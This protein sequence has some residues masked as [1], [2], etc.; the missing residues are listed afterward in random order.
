M[1]AKASAAAFV[2]VFGLGIGAERA[3][4]DGNT[5][6]YGEYLRIVGSAPAGP[7]IARDVAL[8]GD[9]AYVTNEGAL[10]VFDI[11][12]PA[13]PM[14]I[15]FIPGPAQ[16]VAVL[17]PGQCIAV[18]DE[19]FGVRFYD[20]TNPASPT[21]LSDLP[22]AGGAD[23]MTAFRS[24]STTR[25][26]GT[27]G[28][29]YFTFEWPSCAVTLQ[30]AQSVTLPALANDVDG[31]GTRAYVAT[32]VGLVTIDPTMSPPSILGGPVGGAR[33]RVR[34]FPDGTHV[35]TTNGNGFQ[36]WDVTDP[37]NPTE[38]FA[39]NVTSIPLALD[40]FEEI[41]QPGQDIILAISD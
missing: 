6:D 21:F 40:V 37:S 41:H 2:A 16:Q 34:M 1:S 15:G 9:I 28:S 23:R 35:A 26:H 31:D 30:S 12:D 3:E 5:V 10:L 24:G 22:I 4:C 36:T 27:N 33:S 11:A 18:G 14:N 32:D 8:D 19:T 29:S 25:V 7:N 38:V 20:V 17:V 13:N 39:Q